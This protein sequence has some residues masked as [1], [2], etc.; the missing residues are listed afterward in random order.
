MVRRLNVVNHEQNYKHYYTSTYNIVNAVLSA[1]MVYAFMGAKKNKGVR[2]IMSHEHIRKYHKALMF[3]AK[4]AGAGF[5]TQYY[6]TVDSFLENYQKEYA[7]AKINGQVDKEEADPISF[8]LYEMVCFG[9][10]SSGN[11]FDRFFFM[12]CW[13]FM[14]RTINVDGIGFWHLT[15]GTDS[16]KF[17]YFKTKSEQEGKNC[18][19]KNIYTN[20]F[21]PKI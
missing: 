13:N 15:K 12:C 18:Q 17:K 16:I 9:F 6:M 21:N 7:N 1:N 20:P 14:A 8:D 10:L 4:E 3:G 11:I 19:Y 2:K 5:S